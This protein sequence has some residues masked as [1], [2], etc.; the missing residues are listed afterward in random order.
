MCPWLDEHL[1]E[2]S[3]IQRAPNAMPVPTRQFS[4]RAEGLYKLSHKAQEEAKAEAM[5]VPSG[6]S[7][8]ASESI[9]VARLSNS[10]KVL[11]AK[12]KHGLPQ[13]LSLSYIPNLV[14]LL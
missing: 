13:S 7:M 4:A 3:D 9:M 5:M 10:L 12:P 11:R 2:D 14:S 1:P 8:S 6:E